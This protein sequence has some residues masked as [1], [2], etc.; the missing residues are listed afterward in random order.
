M[1]EPYGTLATY[2]ASYMIKKHNA[3]IQ[4]WAAQCALESAT[5]FWAT[6]RDL[7]TLLPHPEDDETP[8][9]E[10]DARVYQEALDLAIQSN[11]TYLTNTIDQCIYKCFIAGSVESAR[12]QHCLNWYLNP[13]TVVQEALI[14][15]VQPSISFTLPNPRAVDFA[16]RRAAEA[17]TEIDDTTRKEI[18]RIVQEG[19][20]D[21]HSY[22]RVAQRINAKFS[23]FAIPKPQQHIANRGVLVAVTEAAN[24]YCSAN[25][26]VGVMLQDS[27]IPM[28]KFWQTLEDNRVSDGC[29][30]NQDAGWIPLSQPFPSG[31]M[32]PPRFP[33]CRC[34]F[35]Q[36]M[37][38]Q[39]ALGGDY[40]DEWAD[41]DR[42]D[43]ENPIIQDHPQVFDKP[44]PISR[45]YA[46]LLALG[47]V[48]VLILGNDKVV[49]HLE[50]KS[51]VPLCMY[52][53]HLRGNQT[54]AA[55]TKIPDQFWSG[56]SDHIAP[57]LSDNNITFQ[58]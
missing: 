37:Q 43:P 13:D 56:Q 34:D 57:Y 16:N 42:F 35:L 58:P 14:D 11:N 6:W 49:D 31:H 52:C 38:D 20:R 53:R 40:G 48:A 25:N 54:C 9:T 47:M 26:D 51:R 3:L 2:K 28:M 32:H 44:G 46:A 18:A 15:D 7:E 45:D 24:A 41:I 29:W 33:G 55:Y 10:D 27:G 4:P 8:I 12:E 17:V 21:G 22:N 23:E 50:G 5:A 30:E 39:S 36:D 19:I 1:A